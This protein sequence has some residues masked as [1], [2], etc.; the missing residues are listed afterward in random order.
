VQKELSA[1]LIRELEEKRTIVMPCRIDDCNVPLFL[2]DK[3]YADF[4]HDPD[5]AFRLVD[6]SLAKIS[7]PLLGRGETPDFHTDW[8]I[9]W[10]NDDGECIK[11][12]TFVDH[13]EN[14]PYVVLSVC[15]VF[16][17]EVTSKAFHNAQGNP[18]EQ[19]SFIREMLT[20]IVASC[21]KQPLLE[22]ISDS[23]EHYVL[24]GVKGEGGRT[25]VVR[26]TYRR[27]G[28]DNG[29]DTVI[30]LDNN[31][32]T[33]LQKLDETTFRPSHGDP[34]GEDEIRLF[35]RGYY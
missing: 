9:D 25:N 3:L 6:Q 7:S 5:E 32:R 27:L 21:D 11:R 14:Y 34:S 4:Y 24:W 28:N 1:G 8:A 12:W 20:N 22:V 31:L 23:H 13:S 26:F 2:R 19:A 10:V 15:T 17:D 33:A 18:T 29:M 16:C 30:H 35:R